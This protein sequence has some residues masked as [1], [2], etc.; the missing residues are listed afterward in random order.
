MLDLQIWPQSRYFGRRFVRQWRT[1]ARRDS[2][3]FR[4]NQLCGIFLCV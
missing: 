3:G 2:P 1:A 4:G